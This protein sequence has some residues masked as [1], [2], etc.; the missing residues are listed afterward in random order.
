M[1]GNR[2]IKYKKVTITHKLKSN[3]LERRQELKEELL[4]SLVMKHY[5][6][7]DFIDSIDKVITVQN[8]LWTKYE[9]KFL[10]DRVRKHLFKT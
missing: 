3:Q 8:F 9:V 4:E 1:P 7:I 5:P 10:Y 6:E 2:A